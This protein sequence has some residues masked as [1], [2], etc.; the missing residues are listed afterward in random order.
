MEK[1]LPFVMELSDEVRAKMEDRM[2]LESD[3]IQTICAY[4]EN[5]MAVYNE[6]DD[7]LT[8]SCRSGN[9]SF[10]IRFREKDDR[11][12]ILSAYSHRMT[13]RIR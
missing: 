2:I 6:S 1:K 7:T 4:R 11:Y 8:A 3:L 10:W 5:G 9:V 12:V 13:V